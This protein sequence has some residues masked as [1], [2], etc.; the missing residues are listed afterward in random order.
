MTTESKR[1]EIKEEW[2]SIMKIEMTRLRHLSAAAEPSAD[3]W[4][5]KT[6]NLQPI[7]KIPFENHRPHPARYASLGFQPNSCRILVAN[8]WIQRTYLSTVPRV[9]MKSWVV[10][11]S[12]M[13]FST[14]IENLG[15]H[16][17]SR[18]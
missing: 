2:R 15:G 6:D 8:Q 12:W 11:E 5:P 1:I 4:Y 10:T 3:N 17:V 16:S 13:P 9:L 7:T 18:K 14:Q